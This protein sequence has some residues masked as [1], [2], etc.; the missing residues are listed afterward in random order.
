MRLPRRL[1]RCVPL[2]YRVARAPLRVTATLSCGRCPPTCPSALVAALSSTQHCCMSP[3][4]APWLGIY[5]QPSVCS[6]LHQHIPLII[7]F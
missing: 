3:F 7:P 6:F 1:Y 4:Y 5:A 2:T